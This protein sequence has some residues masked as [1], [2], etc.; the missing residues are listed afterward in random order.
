[1]PQY[2]VDRVKAEN[3]G[4]LKDKK[5]QV[6][7]V[8]YKPNVADTRETPAELVIKHLI[9]A[10]AK[11]TWHDPLVGKWNSTSSSELGGSDIAVVVTLH[12]N[13]SHDA[14]LAS[15]PYVFDTTGKIKS[16]KWL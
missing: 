5:V 12:A 4:T 9:E 3:S 8:S 11:V 7:G 2:V 14:I 6:I 16:A 10:G 1:M 13:M 15:A